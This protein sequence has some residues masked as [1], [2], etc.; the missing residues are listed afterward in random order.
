MKTY[1]LDQVSVECSTIVPFIGKIDVTD[2]SVAWLVSDADAKGID[3]AQE[4]DKRNNITEDHRIIQG[5]V[6]VGYQFDIDTEEYYID[7]KAPISYKVGQN[8]LY[9]TKSPVVA[10]CRRCYPPG[11]DNYGDLDNSSGYNSGVITYAPRPMDGFIGD[12]DDEYAPTL[13]L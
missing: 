6:L 8:W 12:D 2:D 7:P 5:M 1:N 10:F 13:T 11:I 4:H 9:I 3:L